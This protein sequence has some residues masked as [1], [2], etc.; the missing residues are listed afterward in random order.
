MSLTIP[1]VDEHNSLVVI[2]K[3]VIFQ[4][5]TTHFAESGS[6]KWK[7]IISTT[8][9]T[10]AAA[11]AAAVL[12]TFSAGNMSA[13]ADLN[14]FEAELR[15]EFGIGSAAQFGSADLRS[16]SHTQKNKRYIYFVEPSY[17]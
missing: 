11:A 9:L 2:D 17:Q 8:A 5:P 3:F 16:I 12:T 13:L 1:L 6:S 14:K 15:G 10:T 7:T 4:L